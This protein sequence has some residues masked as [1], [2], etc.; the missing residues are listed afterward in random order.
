ML[1]FLARS[2]THRTA[3]IGLVI[4]VS[5]HTKAHKQYYS[6]VQHLSRQMGRGKRPA[7][8]NNLQCSKSG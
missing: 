5:A 2:P 8:N 6:Q 7:K 3:F 4:Y 1:V